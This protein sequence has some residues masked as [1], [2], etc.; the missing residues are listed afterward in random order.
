MPQFVR[1]KPRGLGNNF[2]LPDLL[3][4]VR[5]P[6]PVI[7]YDQVRRATWTASSCLRGCWYWSSG[8]VTTGVFDMGHFRSPELSRCN[9]G[10]L[11]SIYRPQSVS[12][13]A[14]FLLSP[15]SREMLSSFVFWESGSLHSRA[16]L[17]RASCHL[18]SSMVWISPP[19]CLPA[20]A[21]NPQPLRAMVYCRLPPSTTASSS[22]TAQPTSV[23]DSHKGPLNNRGKPA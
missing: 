15:G 14:N 16:V 21:R 13:N 2:L 8:Y 5:P 19:V 23:G 9:S 12:R 22:P 6:P 10:C 7:L 1:K 20:L 17:L 11:I 3:H 18:Q 4:R